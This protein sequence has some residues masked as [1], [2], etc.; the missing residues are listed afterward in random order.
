MDGGVKWRGFSIVVWN[1]SQIKSADLITY[2]DSG[3]IVPLSMRFDSGND[4]RGAV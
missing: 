2:N 1:S 4:I 3:K